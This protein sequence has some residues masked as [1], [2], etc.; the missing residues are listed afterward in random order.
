MKNVPIIASADNATF[1]IFQATEEEFASIFPNDQDM[2]FAEDLCVRLGEDKA[3][4]VLTCLWDRPILKRDAMGIH[5][6]L[7]FQ[8]A[9][10]RTGHPA[11]KREVDWSDEAINPAQRLLFARHR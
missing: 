2:E 7:Y 10:R 4:Q 5:G 6:T 8:W 11:S 1:S 3:G 9:D